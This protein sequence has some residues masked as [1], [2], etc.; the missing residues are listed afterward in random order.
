MYDLKLSERDGNFDIAVPFRAENNL[1][2]AILISLF[3]DAYV[4]S[5]EAKNYGKE[6]GGG[7]FGEQNIGSKIWLIADGKINN[8][9]FSHAVAF[10]EQ[11]LQWLI[12]DGIA[13]R[14]EVETAVSQIN[15]INLTISLYLNNSI[16]IEKQIVI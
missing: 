5:D 9:T 11:S 14:I 15:R 10:A 16:L 4:E 12:D 2:S 6:E 1:E 8:E 13:D 3:T 7:W